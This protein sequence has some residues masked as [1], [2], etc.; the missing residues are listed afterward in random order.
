M[1]PGT[2]AVFPLHSVLLP[3]GVLPLRIFEPRYLDMVSQCLREGSGF[4]LSLIREGQETGGGA[5]VWPVGAQVRIIDW[6]SLDDGLLG[7]TVEAVS[8]VRLS[9]FR[10]DRD[11]LLWAHA[12]PLPDDPDRVLPPEFATFARLLEKILEQIGPPF[13]RLEAHLDD[14][15]WVAG[16]LTELLPIDP[17]VKQKL[18]EAGDP[19]SRLHLLRDAMLALQVLPEG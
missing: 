11:H 8:R 13:D 14:A 2:I 3:G 17:E 1:K 10:E 15:G 6:D 12:E 9:N 4:V 5:V 16:R 19:L 7:I 18:L